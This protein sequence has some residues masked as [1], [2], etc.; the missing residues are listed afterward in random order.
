MSIIDNKHRIG[1]SRC[2]LSIKDELD[3][4]ER[5]VVHNDNGSDFNTVIWKLVSGFPIVIVHWKE[6][7]KKYDD[8]NMHLVKGASELMA[9][10][11][12]IAGRAANIMSSEVA[13]DSF[14]D[15]EKDFLLNSRYAD[16]LLIECDEEVGAEISNLI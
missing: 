4:L 11:E 1:S 10:K 14:S 3:N 9:I 5:Y 7:G 8:K 13:W 15:E 12:F 6:L 16:C 2:S